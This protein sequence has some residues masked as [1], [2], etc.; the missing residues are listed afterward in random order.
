MTEGRGAGDRAGVIACLSKSDR[1][2]GRAV[3]FHSS[4][5]RPLSCWTFRPERRI[6]AVPAANFLRYVVPGSGLAAEW[7]P[8][9]L[10]G[11]AGT[12][13]GFDGACTF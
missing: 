4:A 6:V 9:V 5:T 12:S 11:Q 3:A 2:E 13:T 7:V 8:P 1:P 10:C